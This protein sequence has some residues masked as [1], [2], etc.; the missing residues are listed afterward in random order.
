[1]HVYM[2]MCTY[3]MSAGMVT[4]SACMH[5][6]IFR[7]SIHVQLCVIGA[8]KYRQSLCWEDY[9]EREREGN[10]KRESCTV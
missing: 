10:H 7:V 2:H 5:N 8:C 1:M 3:R 6:I 9:K 4:M